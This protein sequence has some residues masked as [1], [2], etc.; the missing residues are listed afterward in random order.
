[1]AVTVVNKSDHHEPLW[2][3]ISIITARFRR[4]DF[5][6]VYTRLASLYR[7]KQCLLRVFE[8]QLSLRQQGAYL[9][10]VITVPKRQRVLLADHN[11][12]VCQLLCHNARHISR[13]QKTLFGPC[14]PPPACTQ[15]HSVGAYA[16]SVD[17]YAHR[18]V[19]NE[20]NSVLQC[21]LALLYIKHV[22]WSDRPAL[23]LL[24]RTWPGVATGAPPCP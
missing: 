24:Y 9:C 21:T 1:M 12:C 11:V 5:P 8:L 4:Q 16:H 2:L 17:A 22:L 20:A 23:L 3:F 15:Y 19:S 10:C 18:A 13:R 14:R 6:E 7:R